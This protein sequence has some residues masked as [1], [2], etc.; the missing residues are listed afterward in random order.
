MPPKARTTSKPSTAS[1]TSMTTRSEP[2]NTNSA[3]SDNESLIEPGQL[4]GSSLYNLGHQETAVVTLLI[5]DFE[6]FE[7]F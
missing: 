5:T 1:N 7:P 3:D 4:H 2:T 6:E